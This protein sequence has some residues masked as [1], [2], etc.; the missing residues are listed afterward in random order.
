MRQVL[1][2]PVYRRLLLAY[3][4]TQVA[5][6]VVEVALAILVYRRTGSALGAAAFFLCAQ[7][8]PAF[9]SPP[10]SWPG[11]IAVSPRKVLPS[12]YIV[13]A[14]LFL[15]LALLVGHVAW[16]SSWLWPFWTGSSLWS[17]CR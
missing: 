13:E 6:N 12:L 15:L 11:W 10:R 14:I 17:S 1:R 4:L 3:G 5:W 8:V 16:V 2:L 9:F 7:F